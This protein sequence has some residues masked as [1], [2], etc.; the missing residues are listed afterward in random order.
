[1]KLVVSLKK[2]K[3]LESI[4][5]AER[6]DIARLIEHVPS[7]TIVSGDPAVAVSVEVGEDYVDLL[8]NSVAELCIVDGYRELKTHI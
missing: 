6:Y 8:C 4:R 7:V 5:G 2:E 3:M 1:M